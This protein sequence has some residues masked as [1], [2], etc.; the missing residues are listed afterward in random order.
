MRSRV[1]IILSLAKQGFDPAQILNRLA[2]RTALEGC[3]NVLD[4]GCGKSAALREL[5][6]KK[7][8]G[9]EGYA[10]DLEE[11]RRLKTHDDFVQ[12]DARRL[13]D[14]FSPGQFDAAIA[15]DVIEH[16]PKED[17]LRLMQGMEKIARRKVVFFTPSGFLPQRHLEKTD[18]QEHLSG[19]E[20]AEMQG[21]GYQVK[22]MLG[23]K[24]LRG[25][26]HILKGRPKA[27]WGMISMIGHI[28]WTGWHPA[29]A[30]AIFCVKTKQGD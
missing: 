13:E 3:D 2:L 27:L 21:Y 11:A 6:I 20:A 30:A 1:S 5:G 15:M 9:F 25:E 10:P 28:F 26:F 4:V 17:G 16:L 14:Y 8:T 7:T 23:P 18:L 22:G 29:Q 19:W 12:G 24:K